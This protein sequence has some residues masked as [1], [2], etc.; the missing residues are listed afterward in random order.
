MWK[1]RVEAVLSNI[2]YAIAGLWMILNGIYVVGVSCVLLS[3]GSA[4]HHYILTDKSRIFDFI[5][6]YFVGISTFLFILGL[7]LVPKIAITAFVT[8]IIAVL[9]GSSRV[10]IVALIGL[11]IVAL[12]INSGILS[13]MLVALPLGIAWTFNYIGDNV[14]EDHH[15]EIHGFGWHIASSVAIMLAIYFTVNPILI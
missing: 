9:L 3:L 8:L 1:D 14:H 15:S 4:Y 2:V 5:G 11:V 6:M 7:G 13:M 12:G 10:A